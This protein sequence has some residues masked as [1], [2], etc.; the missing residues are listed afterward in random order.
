MLWFFLLL[1]L[2]KTSASKRNLSIPHIFFYYV[3]FLHLPLC[4]GGTMDKAE[5][6]KGT[7]WPLQQ[8]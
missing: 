6:L 1:Y 3:W 8:N 7:N 4:P 2:E 5:N